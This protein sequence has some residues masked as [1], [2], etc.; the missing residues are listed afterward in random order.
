[1]SWGI[2]ALAPTLAYDSEVMGDVGRGGTIP[3]DVAGA[4]TI[5]TLV[6]SGGTSP[7]WMIDIGRQL[8]DVLPDGRHRVLEDQEHVVPP[9]VLVPV[10]EDFFSDSTV[11]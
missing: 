9:E 1:M 11:S 7:E 6:L 5:P 10:V 4:A 8:A 2:E 3:A